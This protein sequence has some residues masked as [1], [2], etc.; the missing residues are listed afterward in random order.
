MEDAAKKFRHLISHPWRGTEDISDKR[1]LIA[2]EQG[3]EILS[4][5]PLCSATPR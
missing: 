2:L 3:L 1:L 4:V 5:L